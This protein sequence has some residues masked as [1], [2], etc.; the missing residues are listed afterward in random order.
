MIN[1]KMKKAVLESASLYFFSTLFR[2]DIYILFFAAETE[3]LKLK[4]ILKNGKM[5]KY[6]I[7]WLKTIHT[8]SSYAQVAY[9]N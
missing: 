4:V 8:S 9:Q 6:R 3:D 5:E 7:R 2:R 1:S